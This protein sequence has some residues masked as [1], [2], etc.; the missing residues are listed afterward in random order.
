MYIDASHSHNP[1]HT[2]LDFPAS[3]AGAHETKRLTYDQNLYYT[4]NKLEITLRH[5]VVSP[6]SHGIFVSVS[7]DSKH[8]AIL[9][10]SRM[11]LA[12]LYH[13]IAY[14][15]TRDHTG[16]H[17]ITRD[18]TTAGAFGRRKPIVS[19]GIARQHA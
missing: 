6:V 2:E 1:V 11:H 10:W 17:G 3:G 13:T 9:R 15:I 8:I 16:S 12:S 14:G 5:D 19:H 4:H 7:H 18:H